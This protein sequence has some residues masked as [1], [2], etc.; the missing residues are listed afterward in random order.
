MTRY[1]IIF[2]RANCIGA[3]ACAAA[4]PDYWKVTAGKAN[5][6][7]ENKTVNG[8]I[9][10]IIIET[11]AFERN[12]ESAKAC[13]VNVIHVINEETGEQVI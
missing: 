12:L 5:I 8:E 10:E 9:E 4:A 6:I 11:D 3:G 13:P 2:D 1:R 7:K